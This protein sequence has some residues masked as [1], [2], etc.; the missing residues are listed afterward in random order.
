MD[1]G[2]PSRLRTIVV[3]PTVGPVHGPNK[4]EDEASRP[5]RTGQVGLSPM[6]GLVEVRVWMAARAQGSLASAAMSYRPRKRRALL[7]SSPPTALA[8]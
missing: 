1:A 8:R 6:L 2:S 5:T 4:P 3:D 7:R